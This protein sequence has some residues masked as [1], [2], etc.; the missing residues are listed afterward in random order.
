MATVPSVQ[1]RECKQDNPTQ[2]KVCGK[3]TTP[4]LRANW[5]KGYYDLTLGYDSLRILA[6]SKP[7]ASK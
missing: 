2:M 3:E 1:H 6:P 4:P 7:P 5:S